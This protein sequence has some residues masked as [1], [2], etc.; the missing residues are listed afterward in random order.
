MFY[1]P[2]KADM[3]ASEFAQA[4]LGKWDAKSDGFSEFAHHVGHIWDAAEDALGKLVP[5]ELGGF[6][7]GHFTRRYIKDTDT[8]DRSTDKWFVGTRYVDIDTVQDKINQYRK[9]YERER[10]SK[11]ADVRYNLDLL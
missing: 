3:T 4:S 11:E 2:N 1:N 8:D 10:K 9:E 7:S 5:T 6:D